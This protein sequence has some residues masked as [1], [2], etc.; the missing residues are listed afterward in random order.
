MTNDANVPAV[1]IIGLITATP[2]IL[3]KQTRDVRRILDYLHRKLVKTVN[4]GEANHRF[5]AECL[6]DLL[7][8]W[9]GEYP[10]PPPIHFDQTYILH[11]LGSCSEIIQIVDFRSLVEISEIRIDAILL[12]THMRSAHD[13]DI[14]DQADIRIFQW[15][16][17]GIGNQRPFVLAALFKQPNPG[18][19]PF[20]AS[21]HPAENIF[22]PF[23]LERNRNVI[24]IVALYS[25]KCKFSA[26]INRLIHLKLLSPLYQIHLSS[27]LRLS[28]LLV[29]SITD[30][31]RNLTYI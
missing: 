19:R 14:T 13:K 24:Y 21:F 8:P 31:S 3:I 4:Y 29:D 9:S 5:T 22:P 17:H 6:A 10:D 25:M 16:D 20:A 27:S 2:L 7:A 30:R 15:I 1:Q 18:A 26:F 12:V 23:P 11:I 28:L